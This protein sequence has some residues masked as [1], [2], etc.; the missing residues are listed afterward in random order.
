MMSTT[1]TSDI[2][3][4]GTICSTGTHVMEGSGKMIV[5]A[6]GEHSQAGIIFKLL[7]ASDNNDDEKK[8]DKNNSAVRNQSHQDSS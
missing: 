8:P 3:V 4:D 7:G 1:T 6:V 5:T 2:D